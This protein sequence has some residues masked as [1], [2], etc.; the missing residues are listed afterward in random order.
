MLGVYIF[1]TFML[2]IVRDMIH[3]DIKIII[4]IV[5]TIF[6]VFVALI[7]KKAWKYNFLA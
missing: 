2:I 7:Y 5:T 6:F 4:Y 3:E 1:N